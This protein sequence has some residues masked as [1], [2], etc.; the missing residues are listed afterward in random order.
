MIAVFKWVAYNFAVELETVLE[1]KSPEQFQLVPECHTHPEDQIRTCL[2]GLI[3]CTRYV[4][5]YMYTLRMYILLVL[6]NSYIN[7]LNTDGAPP[8]VVLWHVHTES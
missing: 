7:C 2:I 1:R 5:T 3:A 8:S 6:W 4:C